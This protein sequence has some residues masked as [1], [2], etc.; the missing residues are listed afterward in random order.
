MP[1]RTNPTLND[2]EDWAFKLGT[3]ITSRDL[4]EHISVLA[5]DEYEGRETGTEGN[6]KA[7]K[8]VSGV[9]DQLQLPKIGKDQ[10]YFQPV[11]FTFSSW[12][13]AKLEFSSEKQKFLRDFIAFPQM[14]TT[15]E[16][17]AD[18]VLFM[19]YGID[20][21]G[22]S[23]Y[24]GHNIEGK[25]VMVY[26]GEP[27]D[28]KGMSIV[29]SNVKSTKWSQDW[30]YK[31]MV[32]RAR[33]ASMLI[34]VSN[35]LKT[36]VN[37]NRRKLVNRVTEL[38]DTAKDNQEGVNTIFISSSLA[39]EILADRVESIIEKRD[40]IRTGEIVNIYEEIPTT[41]SYSVDIKKEVLHG[42]NV[43]GF[44]EGTD[45]KEE[46]IVISAHYDHVGKKGK[47]VYNGADDNA[48]GTSAVLEIAEAF[49]IAKKMNQGPRRSIL[50]LLV[51]GEE[52]GLLGSEYYAEHP[53]FSLDMTTAD[54]NIDMVGRRG[55]E[56]Q[57]N[58]DPYI[59]VIGSDRLSQDLHDI[60]ESI[61]QQYS[62]LTLDYKYN[63]EKDPNRFYYRS[64]H[65]NFAKHGIPSI[66]FFSG[67]HEDYHRLGDTMDKIDL[68]LLEKRSKHLFYLAWTL[69]N[70]KE[71]IPRKEESTAP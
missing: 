38:G 19:G 54:I 55:T 36:L 70:R 59:Y 56:Y 44:I 3:T 60:N 31:S 65:Y 45:K 58:D 66:F 32:A 14:S 33:G 15:G 62:H 64:D 39:K 5:S 43:L 71:G 41:V 13:K 68:P 25:I 24:E 34:I 46:V 52:K 9:F 61:N 37:N 11:A 22:Y 26:D 47:E 10:S 29:D 12:K 49:A 17:T 57:A 4:Y 48:S 28:V 63:S 2:F 27:I 30:K 67:V 42:N 6:L 20:A 1:D 18:T 35:D 50:C 51:T 23:D 16:I 21:P 40:R 7:A 8:Y 69:A 53:L